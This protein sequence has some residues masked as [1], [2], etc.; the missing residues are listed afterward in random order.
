M[1]AGPP[2]PLRRAQRR[3]Q[4]RPRQPQPDARTRGDAGQRP[5]PWRPEPAV[6]GLPA[7]IV[8]LHVLRPGARTA[9]PRRPEPAA[10]GADDDPRGVGEQRHDGSGAPRVL[11]V[12]RLADGAVGRPG[13]RHL[14]RRHR[15]RSGPGPQRITAGTLVAHHRR[16][17]HPRQRERRAGRAVGRDRG[18][19]P[20]G[21]GQ[22]V[23]DRHRRRPDRVRRRD[24]GRTGA[25][26]A[27]RRMAAFGPARSQDAARPGAGPAQPRFGGAQADLLRLHRGGAPHPAHP[28]GR[29]GCG[30]VGLHGNRHPDGGAL[31]AVA[32]ALRLLRR[33]LRPGHQPTAGRHPRRRRHVDGPGDGARAQPA[34]AVRRVVP[35]DH[36]GAGRCSTT[37]N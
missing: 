8:G 23:P 21:A 3:D 37:T 12:S 13:L 36:A 14:H 7:G 18:Q 16:P 5:H 9:A 6:A 26:R 20:P 27:L 32:T 11:A 4:H 1:A 15:R 17:D 34:R 33:A 19:G 28:D 2:V 29:L 22:D 10:R 35:A 25:G 24:Q 31:A 30:T